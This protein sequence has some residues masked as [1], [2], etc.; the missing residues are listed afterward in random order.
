MVRQ[1]TLVPVA[2]VAAATLAAVE[3]RTVPYTVYLD[4][5]LGDDGHVGSSAGAAVKTLARAI[6]ALQQAGHGGVVTIVP[7]A[8]AGNL[9]LSSPVSIVYPVFIRAL[10][11][12][13]S[14]IR[15]T[16]STP[17]GRSVW[18]AVTT[19]GGSSVSSAIAAYVSGDIGR[20][21]M[22]YG[23]GVGGGTFYDFI[24]DV[25]DGTHATLT[26]TTTIARDST[27]DP[28]GV[29]CSV[30]GD[31]NRVVTDA[32][33]TA[34]GSV[35][36]SASA[37][38]TVA[39]IGTEI[40][41]AG[42]GQGGQALRSA[43]KSVSGNT[44]TIIGVASST[45]S[46]ARCAIGVNFGDLLTYH[47]GQ[48]GLENVIIS[49]QTSG[50]ASI[51]SAIK[52]IAE[53]GGSGSQLTPSDMS[54]NH[55]HITST[56]AAGAWEH[57]VDCDGSW[58]QNT[59]GPGCRRITFD[60]VRFFGARRPTET[61]RL[62][63]AVHWSF[64]GGGIVGSSPTS[65]AQGIAILDPQKTAGIQV[66]TADVNFFGFEG[67]SSYYYSEGQYCGFDGGRVGSTVAVS[68]RVAIE[69][70]PTADHNLVVTTNAATA[71]AT[72]TDSGTNN[73]IK[74]TGD[75]LK[76]DSVAVSLRDR[77]LVAEPVPLVTL[78]DFPTFTPLTTNG[79]GVGCHLYKGQ[80]VS[81]LVC[82]MPHSSGLGSGYSG[83]GFKLALLD[84]AGVCKAVTSDVHSSLGQ[85]QN[86]FSVT[87]AYT[88]PADGWYFLALLAVASGV[89]TPVRGASNGGNLPAIN[90][91]KRMVV[92]FTSAGDFVVGSTYT[93]V[94]GSTAP[95]LAAY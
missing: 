86:A 55:A 5:L 50:N 11:P 10:T 71:N 7:G 25:P 16:F 41:I 73:Y 15:R 90:G 9:D 28:K 6:A 82:V 26:A 65:F 53:D 87:A 81:G 8:G 91:G 57:L 47:V 75:R 88:I 60:D 70:G 17:H 30:V 24:S 40:V 58:N 13:S 43:I 21:I 19:N 51:G 85:D 72:E 18:D 22:V 20:I 92:G 84:S 74:T 83:A 61:I 44:V 63:N 78:R 35:V 69:L 12:K 89:P 34:S 76:E 49:D 67:L 3:T 39:D 64:I 37:A 46:D 4:Q 80:V 2:S 79:Y 77:G 93:P 29:K 62:A 32:A 45:V 38:W 42:A 1:L 68:G 56:D 27:T 54:F 95:Y 52:I 66:A 48:S 36:T 94:D 31:W 59:G 33:M 14:T 23:A